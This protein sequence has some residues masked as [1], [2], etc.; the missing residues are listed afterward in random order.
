M[1]QDARSHEIK[2]ITS[3]NLIPRIVEDENPL[4]KTI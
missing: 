2:E 1:I 3:G 4:G